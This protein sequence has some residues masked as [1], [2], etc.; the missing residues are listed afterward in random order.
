MVDFVDPVPPIIRLYKS[1]LKESVY[2]NTFP[3]GYRL[4]ALLVKQAGGDGYFRIQ[5]IARAD[6]DYEAMN[7]LIRAMNVL[8]NHASY[9][10]GL[11]VIWVQKESNP[12]PGVDDDTGKPEAWC[13]MSV[14]AF[15]A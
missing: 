11:R 2:G 9:L 5:L 4:P 8:E 15:E 13:Y 3:T 7:L 12:I 14:D 1:H 10:D 6:K